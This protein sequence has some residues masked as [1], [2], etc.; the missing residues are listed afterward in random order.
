MSHGARIS[1]TPRRDD[2]AIR[3]WCWSPPASGSIRLLSFSHA[4]PVGVSLRCPIVCIP[5][6]VHS[7]VE[8]AIQQMGTKC[9]ARVPTSIADMIRAHYSWEMAN[10][11]D[12][13]A[14]QWLP[15]VSYWS[16]IFQPA[17]RCHGYDLSSYHCFG[18]IYEIHHPFG[19]WQTMNSRPKHRQVRGWKEDPETPRPTRLPSSK[20]TCHTLWDPMTCRINRTVTWL[21]ITSR[22]NTCVLEAWSVLV[23]PARIESSSTGKI[24]PFDDH[25]ARLW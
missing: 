20:T 12:R 7:G 17:D 15:I 11:R 9:A 19:L 23:W 25:P 22:V 10:Y 6:Q 13:S 21:T 8:E 3:E 16:V 5:P 1:V 18:K 14:H 4:I 24:G 2:M